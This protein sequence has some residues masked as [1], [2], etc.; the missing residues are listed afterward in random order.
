M[1]WNIASTSHWICCTTDSFASWLTVSSSCSCYSKSSQCVCVCLVC[2]HCACL[3]TDSFILFVICALLAI[4]IT[5]CFIGS[6]LYQ[7]ESK[8]SALW[9]HSDVAVNRLAGFLCLTLNLKCQLYQKSARSVKLPQQLTSLLL[10]F[11]PYKTGIISS[12]LILALIDSSKFTNI[13]AN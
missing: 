1:W 9:L 2:A 6:L 12:L 5:C 8:V 3:R 11:V 13:N 10:Q 4:Q 7:P